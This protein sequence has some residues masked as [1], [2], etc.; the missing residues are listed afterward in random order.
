MPTLYEPLPKEFVSETAF[1]DYKTPLTQVLDD[2]NKFGAVIVTKD[3]AYFGIADN[4]T[5]SRSGS[6][7]PLKFSKALS[8]GKFA[9]KLPLLNKDTSIGSTIGYFHEFSTKALPFGEGDRVKGVVKRDMV[10]RAIV[11]LHLL[12]KSK[13]SDAMTT[14][15][16]AIDASANMSQ[17]VSV[18]AQNKIRRLVVMDKGKLFGILTQGEIYSDFAR[19]NERLPELTPQP[20]SLNDVPIKNVANTN[21]YFVDYSS[22]LEDAIK[23][24][25]SKNIS[26]LVVLRGGKPVGILSVKDVFELAAATMEKVKSA[27]VITG[28]DESTLEYEQDMENEINRFIE[29]IDKFGRTDVSYAA[30]HVNKVKN[31]GYE[32]KA[33]L[34]FEKKG[35]IFA[36][37]TGY[38]IDSTLTELLESLMKQVKERKE[39]VISGK[40][41]AERYYGKE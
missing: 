5:L 9:R 3:K 8:I 20:R 26:S 33:R 18:M 41:E 21:P 23:Q 10:L 31:K 27:V 29:K 35:V 32:L 38:G 17:A 15:V 11:S 40:R 1:F 25:L 19:L 4:R 16:M 7:Q 39:M 13:A 14:P 36:T 28:I 37:A 34:G 30:V 12:S 2:M 22:P 6:A 24:L